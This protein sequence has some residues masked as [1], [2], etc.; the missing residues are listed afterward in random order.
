MLV[1]KQ[2]SVCNRFLT[3]PY[4]SY[5]YCEDHEYVVCTEC[6]ASGH[7][8]CAMCDA[9]LHHHDGEKVSQWAEENGVLF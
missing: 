7:T 4:D 9:A 2:C 5:Y 8:A 1:S 6:Y 3:V